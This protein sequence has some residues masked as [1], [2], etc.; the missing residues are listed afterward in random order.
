MCTPHSPTPATGR[1][2][3]RLVQRYP[4]SAFDTLTAKIKL[5]N[6]IICEMPHTIGPL[7]DRYIPLSAHELVK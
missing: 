6:I 3:V 1:T 5:A 2:A 4:P 7:G